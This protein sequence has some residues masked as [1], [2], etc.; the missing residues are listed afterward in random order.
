MQVL[1]AATAARDLRHGGS[2]M[3]DVTRWPAGADELVA[4]QRE[5]GELRPQPWLQPRDPLL[6]G[7]FACFPRGC[8]GPGAAGDPIWAG[9]A[10]FRGRRRVAAV[11]SSGVAGAPYQ[12]GLLA[13]RIGPALE[14]AVRALAVV[15]DALL[16]DATGCDH[17]RH[18]GLA[19]HLGAVLDLPTVGVTHRPL[20]AAGQWPAD[21]RGATSALR[22]DGMLVG[23]WLRTRSGRRPVAVHAGW[24]TDAATAV[25]I[26]LAS[27]RHRTPAPLREARRLARQVRSDGRCGPA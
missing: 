1:F 9:A 21:V 2:S 18:A 3:P 11:T 26:A 12:P 16:V 17:P 8:S 7:C 22:L 20:L 23:Y 6:G 14:V 15:P 5:L 19:R 25:E 10:A 4:L 24:R 13:L 27:G